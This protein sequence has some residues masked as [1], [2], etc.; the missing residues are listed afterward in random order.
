MNSRLINHPLF[1][2]NSDGILVPKVKVN[3]EYPSGQDTESIPERDD[4][5]SVE[6][7]NK[8][9]SKTTRKRKKKFKIKK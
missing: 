5:T 4:P 7:V 9:D 3:P 6:T 1:E 8:A 2:Y